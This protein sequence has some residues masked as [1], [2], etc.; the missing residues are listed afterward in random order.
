MAKY[1]YRCMKCRT[2]NMFLR[3]VESYARPR[4]CLRCG[5]DR[6]YWDKA[7]NLRP[8]IERPTETCYCDSPAYA[9]PHRPGAKF[10]QKNPNY[11]FNLRTMWAGENATEVMV[12]MAFNGRSGTISEECPF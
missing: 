7:R 8:F 12:D 5:H 4:R 2:R 10:C 1:A 6:F 11:E 9:H 3:R